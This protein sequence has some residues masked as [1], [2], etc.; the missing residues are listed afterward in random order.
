MIYQL[1][2][3][4][5]IEMSVEQYLSMSDAELEYL[6]TTSAGDSI[7]NPWF[8]SVLSKVNAHEDIEEYIEDNIL[9]DDDLYDADLDIEGEVDLTDI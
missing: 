1:K 9:S 6:N 4:S 3:G 7:D 8:G 5:T 2:N